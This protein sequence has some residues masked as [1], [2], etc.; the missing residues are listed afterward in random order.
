MKGK[1]HVEVIFSACGL[2]AL[3]LVGA[4]EAAGV[5]LTEAQLDGVTAGATGGAP[6]PNNN[7]GQ[8]VSGC[9]ATSCYPGSTSRG[10]YVSGQANKATDNNSYTGQGYGYEIHT[11]ANPGNSDPKKF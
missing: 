8:E 10:V 11:L 2:S 1:G 5:T 3:G 9:N 4:A 7:W 6:G